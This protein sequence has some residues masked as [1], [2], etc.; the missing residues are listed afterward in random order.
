MLAVACL[1][2]AAG[3]FPTAQGQSESNQPSASPT[4]PTTLDYE[5]FKIKVQPAPMAA[6]ILRRAWLNGKFQG[7]K[8]AQT[9]IG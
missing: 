4:A 1:F 6:E 9:P 8:A 7:V 5:F 2:L 3:G